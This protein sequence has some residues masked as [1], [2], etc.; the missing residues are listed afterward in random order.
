MSR[1]PGA[2]PAFARVRLRSWR[3]DSPWP[4]PCRRG[5]V[6]L[7][8]E[9]LDAD[10][11]FAPVGVGLGR[12]LGLLAQL[13]ASRPGRARRPPWSAGRSSPGRGRCV[14]PGSGALGE[15]NRTPRCRREPNSR[16]TRRTP[17]SHA[18][19]PGRMTG[20]ESPTKRPANRSRPAAQGSRTSRLASRTLAIR[21]RHS[22]RWARL[23]SSIARFLRLQDLADPA[24][25]LL[26]VQ[27]GQG[28]GVGR[29]RRSRRRG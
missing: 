21:C 6:V 7:G 19:T 27:P 10:D 23:V 14:G 13:A 22:S 26:Q 15:P 4:T 3:A 2:W 25:D 28:A 9:Q 29:D 1:R 24:G 8:V 20:G 11:V 12:P 5:L 18:A 16:A 17:A